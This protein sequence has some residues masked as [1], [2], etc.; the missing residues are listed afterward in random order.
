MKRIVIGEDQEKIVPLFWLGENDREDNLEIVLAGRGARLTLIGLLL[1]DQDKVYTNKTAII[2]AAPQTTSRA[3]IRGVLS[4]QA[5]INFDGL[6]RIEKGAKQSDAHMAAHV[7]L[8]SRQAKA[9]AV[10]SLEIDENDVIC[11]HAAAVGKIDEEQLFYLASRGL[12]KEQATQL[13]VQGFFADLMAKLPPSRQVSQFR[14]HL[15]VSRH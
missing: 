2:H 15:L 6:V 3:I 5:K 11:G 4:H 12:S 1:G 13:V 10:P 7:L 9:R 8:L 14:R